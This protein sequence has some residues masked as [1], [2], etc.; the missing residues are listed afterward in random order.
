M[1]QFWRR[2]WQPTP[3]FLPGKVHGQRSLA[4]LSPWDYMHEG[5]G[6]WVGSN[7]VVELKKKKKKEAVLQRVTWS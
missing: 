6:R 2:N 1:R 4:G 3:V 5:G 7:K